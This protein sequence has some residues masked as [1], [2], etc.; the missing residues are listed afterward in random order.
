[1]SSRE[2]EDLIAAL[3]AEEVK[4][5]AAFLVLIVGTLGTQGQGGYEDAERRR[6]GMGEFGQPCG[7]EGPE[8]GTGAWSQCP[9]RMRRMR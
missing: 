6:V 8:L 1:M 7:L 2:K 9:R 4:A 5:A 3:I